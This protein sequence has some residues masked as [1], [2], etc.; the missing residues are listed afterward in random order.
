MFE[1]PKLYG[2]ACSYAVKNEESSFDQ[3]LIV[4]ITNLS[5]S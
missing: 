1:I 2:S 3:F 5:Y 4:T